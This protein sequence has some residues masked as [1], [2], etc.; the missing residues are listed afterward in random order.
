MHLRAFAALLGMA[1]FGTVLAH[2]PALHAGAAAAGVVA[3]GEELA[4]AFG[5]A[6]LAVV[7]ENVV[8]RATFTPRAWDDVVTFRAGTLPPSGVTLTMAHPTRAWTANA[9][10]S[11]LPDVTVAGT[12][13]S[14]EVAWSFTE[15]CAPACVA[16]QP[17]PAGSPLRV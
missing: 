11:C 5:G 12:R 16:P 14:G 15:G 1:C 13:L 9:P 10:T 17:A 3:P 8:L 2:S 6:C 7:R 4:A